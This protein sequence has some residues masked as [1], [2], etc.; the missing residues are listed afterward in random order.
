MNALLDLG[1]SRLKWASADSAP[2]K[3]D[4]LPLADP[5]FSQNLRERLGR[6]R[7]P[8]QVLGASVAPAEKREQVDAVLDAIGWPAATW[9]RS[10]ARHGR[11]VSAYAEPADLGIDRF[12]A[13]LAALDAG[14]APC[15]IASCGTALT[16]DALA[17]DG[18]HLGGQIAPGVGA[19]QSA[20]H[21]A[22]PSLPAEQ[23]GQCVDFAR[24]TVDA[25]YSGVW[26]TSAA[27]IERFVAKAAERLQCAPRLLLHGGNAEATAAVL[28]IESEAF[29]SA[30]LRGLRVWSTTH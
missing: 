9:L 13:L 14:L 25:M 12:L 27:T 20:L 16:L 8:Q 4:S 5:G 1:N 15:V 21:L 10:P 11:L 18:V 22:A 23:H 17:G 24:G 7:V 19:M 30:V 29:P 2:G 26:N 28:G 6:H 3:A